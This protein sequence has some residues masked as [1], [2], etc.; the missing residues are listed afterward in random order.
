MVVKLNMPLFH[1][2]YV[3]VRQIPPGHVATYGQVAELIGCTARTVGFAMAALKGGGDVPWQRVINR[4]GKVSSRVD[5][6]GNLLQRDLLE[7]EGV[8]FDPEQ[9]IDLTVFGWDF[10]EEK[11]SRH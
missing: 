1:Q 6:E 4:Q 3:L 7:A 10:S 2:I 11:R 5:G 9:Q 8:Y